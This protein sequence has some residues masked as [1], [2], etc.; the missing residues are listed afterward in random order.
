MKCL[1]SYRELYQVVHPSCLCSWFPI[2]SK[3]KL[4]IR[5]VAGIREGAQICLKGFVN[6]N[7]SPFKDVLEKHL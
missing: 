2:F 3:I 1:N 5:V 7:L 6:L 4:E